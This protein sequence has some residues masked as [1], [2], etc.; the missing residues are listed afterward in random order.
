MYSDNELFDILDENGDK[1]GV[2]KRRGDVHRDGDIHGSVHIWMTRCV[3]GCQQVLVQKRADT[4]DS[5]P[6]CYD[7]AVTGHIDTGEDALSAAL[8][9]IGEEAG[10]TA[11]PSDLILLYRDRVSEDNIFKGK[12]FINNEICWVYLYNAEVYPDS[13]SFEQDEISAM[14]WQ[15][16]T[17]VLSALENGDTQY[18]LGLNELKAVLRCINDIK[19]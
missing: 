5:Y 8:R 11:K 15:P 16:A 19:E 9:E 10:I 6:G 7:A 18:C 13:I 12:R 14:E 1:T 17:D 3:D 4:K 2:T